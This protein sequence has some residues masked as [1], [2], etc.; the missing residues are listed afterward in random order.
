MNPR[1]VLRPLGSLPRRFLLGC[2][3]LLAALGLAAQSTGTGTITGRVY[4]PATKEYVR[5][6]EVRIE[7]TRLLTATGDGGYYTFA[8]VPAGPAAVSV[9]FTGYA[10][11][12]QPVTVTAGQTATRDLELASPTPRK[13]TPPT[14]PSN[15]RP[16]SSPRKLR[17]MRSRS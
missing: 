4:N 1:L 16:S 7:G 2:A 11:S 3:C 13:P 17:A 9:S 12:T 5:D 10:Q 8:N 6:A 14:A 15:S